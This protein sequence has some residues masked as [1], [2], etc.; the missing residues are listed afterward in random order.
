MSLSVIV[1]FINVYIMAFH[2]KVK[3]ILIKISFDDSTTT[4]VNYP[5]HGYN[6]SCCIARSAYSRGRQLDVKYS[7]ELN[8]AD[9]EIFR[10]ESFF[11]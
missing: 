2:L 3:A 4:S 8:I 7:A 5:D 10:V 1:F 6:D 9:D 11:S